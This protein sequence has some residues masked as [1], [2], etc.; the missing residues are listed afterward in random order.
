MP[1]APLERRRLDRISFSSGQG[2]QLFEKRQ[3]E[4]VVMKTLISFLATLVVLF[5]LLSSARGDLL[6]VGPPD[7]NAEAVGMPVA[8]I[9][10]SV[11]FTLVGLVQ[12]SRLT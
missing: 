2:G 10:A 3:V 8:F 12:R 9:L 7:S 5:A 11:G 4:D 6:N 1:F